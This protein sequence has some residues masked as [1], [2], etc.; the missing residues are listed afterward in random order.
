MYLRLKY[1]SI[2]QTTQTNTTTKMEKENNSQASEG[3]GGGS[4]RLDSSKGSLE[5][6]EAR[7]KA[8]A[9][10]PRDDAFEDNLKQLEDAV[11]AWE[12][13]VS[14]DDGEVKTYSPAGGLGLSTMQEEWEL[15][16]KGVTM[17]SFDDEEEAG[18]EEER[19]IP[20]SHQQRYAEQEA[21]LR[22]LATAYS[23]LDCAPR[24]DRE[25]VAYF[26]SLD[27]PPT[28]DDLKIYK[29]P[30]GDRWIVS[31]KP[32]GMPFYYCEHEISK[33]V[34]CRKCFGPGC[35]GFRDLIYDSGD[36][37]R[38]QRWKFQFYS[39]DIYPPL[40]KWDRVKRYSGYNAATKFGRYIRGKASDS[41]SRFLGFFIQWYLGSTY[42]HLTMLFTLLMTILIGG[43]GVYWYT[44]S[45]KTVRNQNVENQGA[46]GRV[47]KHLG[48]RDATQVLRVLCDIPRIV[49]LGNE[50]YGWF[51]RD[52][53][54]WATKR[55]T[56]YVYLNKK[57]HKFF[58]SENMTLRKAGIKTGW[59]H[60]RESD[61]G[62]WH[63]LD[64]ASAGSWRMHGLMVWTPD[65]EDSDRWARADY[66]SVTSTA[67]CAG[68][69][70]NIIK[71]DDNLGLGYASGGLMSSGSG[72]S[73]PG[74]NVPSG[75]SSGS[76]TF[77]AVSPPST[78]R[79]P[80]SKST[81]KRD[82]KSTVIDQIADIEEQSLGDVKDTLYY[83]WTDYILKYG[84]WPC[85]AVCIML[86]AILILYALYRKLSEEK[87]EV[88]ELQSRLEARSRTDWADRVF[89]YFNEK[90]KWENVR[91]YLVRGGDNVKPVFRALHGITSE[92]DKERFRRDVNSIHGPV[93]VYLTGGKVIT[94]RNGERRSNSAVVEQVMHW[95]GS[96]Y[97][98]DDEGYYDKFKDWA[99]RL[100][101]KFGFGTV[102]KSMTKVLGCHPSEMVDDWEGD[103]DEIE[104]QAAELKIVRRTK[105]AKDDRVEVFLSTPTKSL[106]QRRE[107][108][109]E[110]KSSLL[111]QLADQFR[112]ANEDEGPPPDTVEDDEASQ[113]R[114][115]LDGNGPVDDAIVK[116]LRKTAPI[117]QIASDLHM[118][119]LIRVH[120]RQPPHGYLCAAVRTGNELLVPG[121]ALRKFPCYL[122]GTASSMMFPSF[123]ELP[124]HE[125]RNDLYAIVI[126]QLPSYLKT[127][128]LANKAF[129]VFSEK[130][131]GS[132]NH[133]RYVGWRPQ[134]DGVLQPIDQRI[135]PHHV[136]TTM[137]NGHPR[138]VV[139]DI[140]GVPGMC[141]NVLLRCNDV[142]GRDCKLIGI[143][144]QGHTN[145]TPPIYCTPVSTRA[146][147]E[148]RPRDLVDAVFRK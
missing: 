16:G 93:T 111:E 128:L 55:S 36:F 15:T 124:C 141:G 91:M 96:G 87:E 89:G 123:N 67:F 144:V 9:S 31:A 58:F 132:A 100:T 37:T 109:E 24:I 54:H 114:K 49:D 99:S 39:Q 95:L 97:E 107:E 117:D 116:L 59:M 92:E 60:V 27:I 74:T 143:H 64:V 56:G 140:G 126:D 10:R 19:Y 129:P 63:T 138:I 145:G 120:D 47:F 22:V 104:N 77:S 142:D 44:R 11:N 98:E 32:M 94:M 112:V 106:E 45:K 61:Y 42:L 102:E 121:H 50:V 71:T 76:G 73:G 110:R 134:K 84:K 119:S 118:T 6:L 51:F 12:S 139:D 72:T 57:L 70:W 40:T 130:E 48:I 68:G 23:E 125:V 83:W 8:L 38:W 86:F 14:P 66:K 81:D 122:T 30:L 33:H 25:A 82:G 1:Y 105:P 103:K 133:Y 52:P 85:V 53:S 17:R 29:G 69:K 4:N 115:F 34:Y 21:P 147:T 7:V 148:T 127:W 88:V 113:L 5:Q 90:I 136:T 101:A 3:G 80:R 135:S 46:I 62:V 18:N 13:R 131:S 137:L 28:R 20:K 43:G 65:G 2:F 75:S 41:L 146:I 78:T 35:D 26:D 108:Y 79:R